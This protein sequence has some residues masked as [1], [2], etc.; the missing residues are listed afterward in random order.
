MRGQKKI[1]DEVMYSSS[2]FFE[3][4]E[5][6]F[7]S[8]GFLPWITWTEA[9]S[10]ASS[11]ISLSTSSSSSSIRYTCHSHPD[12]RPLATLSRR[13]TS[14]GTTLELTPEGWDVLDSIILTGLLVLCGS[15]DWKRVSGIGVPIR[16]E[17]PD[18]DRAS[19]DMDAMAVGEEMITGL[20]G[21][22]SPPDLLDLSPGA[23]SGYLSPA[24]GDSSGVLT[25]ARAIGS[26]TPMMASVHA[27]PVPSRPASPPPY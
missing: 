9:S 22:T 6:R 14:A 2:P 16:T 11:T 4:R 23:S 17:E 24:M 26:L 3:K 21:W 12:R 20:D 13:I 8:P 19:M 10:R 18:P 7:G 15:H 1:V 27:S 5:R 25:P